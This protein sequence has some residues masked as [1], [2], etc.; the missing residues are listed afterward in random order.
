MKPGAIYTIECAA[1]GKRY[2]GST[3][4]SPNQRRLEHLHHLRRGRHHSRRLQRCF[5][6][7]GED[8]LAFSVVEVVDDLNM[9]LPREQFHIWRAEGVCL[10]S[11]DVSDSVHCARIAN[12]GRAQSADE[13][14]RRSV[15][16]LAAVAA[17]TK[18]SVCW[19]DEQRAAQSRILTGRKMPEVKAST[20]ENISKALIG[21]ACPD[22]AIKRS[23]ETRTAFIAVELPGWLA[24]RAKGMSYREMEKITG[25]SR[26]MLERECSK[27]E[28]EARTLKTAAGQ[29]IPA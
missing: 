10:N 28:N 2:V 27:A 24:M 14:A 8:S 29:A 23:V 7:Y 17:G 9:L 13:R 26:K 18:K 21:R 5:D 19:T 11:A 15:A 6:K 25:R 12:T 22:L 3:S 16:L 1:N 20:R 4:R